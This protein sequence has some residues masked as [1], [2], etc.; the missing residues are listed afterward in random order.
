MKPAILAACLSLFALPAFASSP[1]VEMA[2]NLSSLVALSVK[3]GGDTPEA[4]KA[5]ADDAQKRLT[6]RCEAAPEKSSEGVACMAKAKTLGDFD[7]CKGKP[8]YKAVDAWGEAVAAEL[9][10]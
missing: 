3:G 5:L 1:C 2:K 4:F 8:G 10:K 7:K 9:K 6:K